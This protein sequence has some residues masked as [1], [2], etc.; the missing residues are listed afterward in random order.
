MEKRNPSDGKL[1]RL[2]RST[3]NIPY[4]GGPRITLAGVARVA[5]QSKKVIIFWTPIT[6]N[7]KQD[8]GK[9]SRTLTVFP[10]LIS[11]FGS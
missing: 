1:L 5:T 11:Y 10:K 4:I 3:K 6:T 9:R 8:F 2:V 7:L